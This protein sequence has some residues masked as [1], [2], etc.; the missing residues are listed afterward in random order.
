MQDIIHS[1]IKRTVNG[2]A[3]A[4]GAEVDLDL[5][6]GYP[7]TKNDLELTKAMIPALYQ[8]AGEQNVII[9]AA[10]TGAEDFSFFAN[11]VPSLYWFTGGRPS[12]ISS[13][14]A[15]PHHTPDFYIDES[16]LLTGV[17]AMA[18]VA[19]LYMK[20]NIPTR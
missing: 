7:V 10:S 8:A 19:T 17:R 3:E 15:T 1:K 4:Y 6:I 13:N 9:T 20:N 5:N 2:I 18:Q 12:N 16:G 14:E 11:K